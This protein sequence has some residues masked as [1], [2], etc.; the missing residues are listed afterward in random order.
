LG[1]LGFEPQMGLV[2]PA[3]N[4]LKTDTQEGLRGCGNSLTRELELK[5]VSNDAAVPMLSN[6]LD[7]EIPTGQRFN[8][9]GIL[10]CNELHNHVARNLD[11]LMVRV[12]WEENQIECGGGCRIRSPRDRC[13]SVIDLN[14][15]NLKQSVDVFGEQFSGGR[16]GE[17]QLQSSGQIL[18]SRQFASGLG[19]L[20][21]GAAQVILLSPELSFEQF[22]ISAATDQGQSREN[23][24]RS[25][26][27]NDTPSNTHALLRDEKALAVQRIHCD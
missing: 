16:L 26:D 2:V 18:Q 4:C 13:E 20:R 27:A 1:L 17:L 21:L 24:Q 8:G 5:P 6:L 12:M 14:A 7:G 15:L 19:Q 3:V 23:H 25:S 9:L 11:R 22:H 10:D